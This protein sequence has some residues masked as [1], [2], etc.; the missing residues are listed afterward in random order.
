MS[1]SSSLDQQDHPGA[2][3]PLVTVG[4]WFFRKRS[5]L[6]IP[7][8]VAL[9]ALPAYGRFQSAAL[10]AVGLCLVAAGELTRLWAVRHIGVI[11]RTRAD[12]LGPL[13]S[14]GPFAYVRNP[15]YLGNIA[16]WTGFAVS[17]RIV[18]LAPV[19]L[20]VAGFVYHAI[21]L[22]E[23][24]LL[25]SRRGQDYREYAARV[26]RWVPVLAPRTAADHPTAL[27]SWRDTLASERST[28][29]AVAGGLLLLWAKSRWQLHV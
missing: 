7:F 28:L 27:F 23:E 29:M 16:I 22:W 15:L 4:G 6:P 18:W 20:L 21:V 11:S 3:T 14:T 13:V 2:S 12:R 8:I 24:Q 1:A 19:F 9:L 10:V 25:A 17:A 26:S 5:A